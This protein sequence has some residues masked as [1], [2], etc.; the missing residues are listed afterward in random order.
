MFRD[1]FVQI[2]VLGQIGRFRPVDRAMFERGVEVICRT[3]RGLEVGRVLA[4][5]ESG[6]SETEISPDGTLL[7]RISD[8]DRMLI[9]RLQKNRRSAIE[10]CNRLLGERNLDAVLLDVEH[11]FDGQSLYFYFL[12]E[13]EPDVEALTDELADAY[14]AKVRFRKF[15]EKLLSGCGPDC[16]TKDCSSDSCGSCLLSGGCQSK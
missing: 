10:Q 1:Y 2:G 15:S 7:R 12:G 16:G 5:S 6:S 3:P 8:D 4:E 14:E 13:V 9:Q 11:L